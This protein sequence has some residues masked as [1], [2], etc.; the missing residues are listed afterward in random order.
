MSF[1][2]TS[3]NWKT[4]TPKAI[5]HFKDMKSLGYS[6]YL[7]VIGQYQHMARGG[8]GGTLGFVPKS[9]SDWQEL[10]V[11]ALQPVDGHAT[12]RGYN[13]PGVPDEFFAQVLYGLGEKD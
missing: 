9:D 1:K 3:N 10:L 4:E 13:Y 8:Q 2:V 6:M 11:D 12:V 5:E 7:E